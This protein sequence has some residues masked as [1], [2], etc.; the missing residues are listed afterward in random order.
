MAASIRPLNVNGTTIWVEVEDTVVQPPTRSTTT[1]GGGT[2]DTSSEAAQIAADGLTKVDIAATLQAILQPVHQAL[3][4]SKP[5]EVS[6]ELSLGLKGEIGVFVAKGE[7][8]ASLK[9]TA[10]WK[11]GNGT[12]TK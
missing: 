8:N 7:G 11:T 3:Q 9:V 4:A 1:R 5:D 6:V 2:V 12:Q 10:K